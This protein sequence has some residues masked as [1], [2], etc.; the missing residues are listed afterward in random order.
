MLIKGSGV[1]KGLAMLSYNFKNQH[2]TRRRILLGLRT[3]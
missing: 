3:F 1:G 2:A